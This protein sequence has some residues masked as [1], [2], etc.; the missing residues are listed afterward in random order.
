MVQGSTQHII[1]ATPVP[2][3]AVDA[4][5]ARLRVAWERVL[6]LK[7]SDDAW[8]RA[9]LPL[10]EGGLA[11]GAL[12]GLVPRAAAAFAASWS[13]TCAFVAG[14]TGFQC[15]SELVAEDAELALQL[16]ASA[17]KL[18]AAGLSPMCTPWENLEVPIAFN[19]SKLLKKLSSTARAQCTSALPEAQAAQWRSSSGPG[20][21][22]YLLVPTEGRLLVD[23]LLFQISVARRF[24]GGIQSTNANAVAP[25]CA[26]CSPSGRCS[27]HLDPH[28]HHA[29]TCS[30]GGYPVR[31]HNRLVRWLAGWLKD[32]RADSEVRC[33][34]SI[35]QDPPG[36][37]DIIVGHGD[38]QVWID[39]AIVAPTSNCQRTLQTRSRRD[40]HAARTE[41]QVKRR[42]YGTRV[43][44]F[45]IESGG[46][47]GFS[48]RTILM[49][50]ALPD[51]TPSVEI[52]SAWLAISS[53][54]QSETSLAMLTAWGGS[55]ALTGGRAAIF[56]P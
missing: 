34:Q 6:G 16:Q 5:D 24:G 7:L 14:V 51:T 47:P 22:G 27:A 42:R 25:V 48:T 32:D 53:I 44:P 4:Y 49:T 50:F 18:K 55:P 40:G 3:A 29:M 12:D 19:Q 15:P 43:S 37:M 38:S 21:S 20:S 35:V 23:N 56:V 54:I 13:R 31:R 10:R 17:E 36:R 45:V 2:S 33:E 1:S 52:G 28:G 46:R 39:V 8:Q 26:H 9:Q 41:E 30:R 11:S